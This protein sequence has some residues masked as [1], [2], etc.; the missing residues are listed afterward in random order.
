MKNIRLLLILLFI[1]PV[2]ATAQPW[3]KAPYLKK[4]KGNADFFEICNAFHN[5]WGNAPY[6]KGRGYKQFKRWEFINFPRCFPDGTISSTDKYYKAFQDIVKDYKKSGAKADYSSWTPMGITDW[7]NGPNGYNPGNG[8]VNTVCVS[9]LNAQVIFVGAPSGGLWKSINGGNSWNTTFDEMPHLG[10]SSIAVHP[11]SSNVVFV[12]TGDRDA[13][14]SQCIGIYKSIDGGNT[15][16]PSGLNTPDAWNSINKIVF[17]PLKPSTMFAATYY[18]VY[19]STDR[20]HN[21]TNVYSASWVTNLVF[22]PSDTSVMYGSGGF[23]IRSDDGGNSFVQNTV[24]PNDT[25]RLEI[26]VTPANSNYVYVVSSN[27]AN[28]FG[29]LFRSVDNGLTFTLRSDSPNIFG[30]E[31]DAS[32]SAGQAWYDLAIAAS[33]SNADEILVGG[34]NVWKSNNGGQNWTISSHWIYDTIHIYTHADIHYLGF[35]GSRLYCGSDGGIFYSVDTGTSWADISDGLGITQFYRLA[36]SP[37]DPNL[38]VAGAQDE[39]SNKLQ[40][41]VWTHIFG[42]DGMQTMTDPTDINTYYFSYQSGGIMKTT[43]NGVTVD[44][45]IPNDSIQGDWLTPFVMDP[46]DNNIIYAGY[47]DVYKSTDAGWTWNKISDSLALGATLTHLKIAPGN[48]DYIYASHEGSIYITKN[49]GFT[50]TAKSVPFAGT[51]TDIAV[52]DYDP[53]KIWLT[54]S[55]SAGDRVFKSLN[56]GQTFLNIT[57]NLNGTGVRCIV[58][59]KNANDALYVGTEN[60]VFYKDTTLTQWVPFFQGLPNVIVNQLEINEQ[61][62]KIRAATYGRGIWESLLN[63]IAGINEPKAEKPYKVYP[64]PSH[65]V[66]NIEFKTLMNPAIYLFDINGRNLKVIN[67]T[68]SDKVELN[69]KNLVSGVYFIRIDAGKNKWV[70]RIVLMN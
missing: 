20:G 9:P 46:T 27:P 1:V 33:P 70:E 4:T 22:N 3:M 10:V 19:K 2:V 52:S 7:V 54:V 17:N 57:G 55:G 58:Y 62:G 34:I 26:A 32:D 23:F 30:Y 49:G 44:Y 6:V 37:I 50:W 14:D 11:D 12:G 25:I 29:G 5:Y 60:A 66:V 24:L 67:N 8:R 42:A 56:A 41:G 36:S 69:L 68:N 61:A 13:F 47:D 38:I 40:G 65:G 43:D 48:H 15:F 53:E 64:N 35:S 21:W 31:M 28:Q 45:I 51:I 16:S 39:G 18:G 63:P 59:Q